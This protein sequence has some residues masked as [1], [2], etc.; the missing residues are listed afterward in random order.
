MGYITKLEDGRYRVFVTTGSAGKRRRINKTFDTESEA[1]Q[2]LIELSGELGARIR[3]EKPGWVY[4]IQNRDGHI[5][6][7]FTTDWQR[8]MTAY[9]ASALHTGGAYTVL[10]VVAGTFEDEKRLHRRFAYCRNGAHEVYR[11]HKHL[12][13]F[14]HRMLG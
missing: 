2:G 7:G 1:T 8:R 5:K 3:E 14:I 6:I 13:N 11:P 12:L 9:D 10:A 4:F